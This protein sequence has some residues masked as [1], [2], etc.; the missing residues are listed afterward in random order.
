MGCLV[1][2]FRWPGASLRTH[3]ELKTAPGLRLR[4]QFE[5]FLLDFR[6]ITPNSKMMALKQSQNVYI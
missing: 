6:P 3:E 5:G 1:C 4:N 2:T